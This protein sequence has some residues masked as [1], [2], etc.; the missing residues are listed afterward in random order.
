MPAV[1]FIGLAHVK[2]GDVIRVFQVMHRDLRDLSQLAPSLTPSTNTA[3]Q[4]AAK[5]GKLGAP[6]QAQYVV[7]LSVTLCHQI[8]RAFGVQEPPGP[9]RQFRLGPYVEAAADVAPAKGHH[10][11][12]V[13]QLRAIVGDLGKGVDRHW[14][15]AGQVAL[16]LWP[17]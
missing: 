4:I 8:D 1:P 9:D 2:R 13:Q 11:P 3:R 15:D 7:H 12:H 14:R 16:Y 5:I 17:L 6:E 10:V